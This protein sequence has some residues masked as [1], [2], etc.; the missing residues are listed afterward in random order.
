M[1]D[2][3]EISKYKLLIFDM[4]GTLF[5]TSES[6]YWSYHDAAKQF[7]YEINHDKFLEVFV[8][9]NYKEFL[10]MFGITREN[11]LKSIHDFKKT[12]YK[13]YISKINKN[14]ALFFLMEELKVGRKL[15]LATTASKVNTLDVLDYFDALKYFDYI[16]TQED[17]FKLKPDP[18]CYRKVMDKLQI[19]PMD[20]IIFED[21]EV[22]I[23]AANASGAS[24]VKVCDFK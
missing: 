24:C 2:L 19:S 20:T 3:E 4:D 9:R 10:P 22:G 14:D 8:G 6:N 1:Y 18:E 7:G 15:A 5:D 17:V 21:S 11:E 16:L 12:H 13:N 23:E